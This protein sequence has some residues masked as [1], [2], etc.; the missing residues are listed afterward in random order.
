[1]KKSKKYFFTLFYFISF[2]NMIKFTMI[3][4]K[5]VIRMF[6]CVYKFL[7]KDDE[8][9]YIGKATNL[10]ARLNSHNHLD[11]ECYK[12]RERIEFVQFDTT[13]DMDLAERYYISKYKPKY[14]QDHRDKDV[15]LSLLE[16]DCKLW[17]EFNR[18]ILDVNISYENKTLKFEMEEYRNKLNE[19]RENSENAE[20]NYY[21]ESNPD[22]KKLMKQSKANLNELELE[23]K[24]A[25]I[26]NYL[27]EPWKSDIYVKYNIYDDE[28][29][30]NIEFKKIEDSIFNIC[31]ERILE[32][33][34]Y[35][36]KEYQ[37]FESDLVTVR[38][39]WTRLLKESYFVEYGLIRDFWAIEPSKRKEFFDRVTKNVEDRLSI[40]FGKLIQDVVITDDENHL[41]KGFCGYYD[42]IKTKEAFLVMKPINPVNTNQLKQAND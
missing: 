28:D 4:K 3:D 40:V 30:I 18:Q 42:T 12:E 27:I 16:L 35:K 34:Y 5:G 39:S 14:N 23:I 21:K 19:Y 1:M 11:A 20:A 41:I 8:I 17:T 24:N 38:D 7:N 13:D 9:I 22:T 25:L 29:I 37:R 36:V 10:R 31:H 15:K 32:N 6:N 33:G 2:Y 26:G